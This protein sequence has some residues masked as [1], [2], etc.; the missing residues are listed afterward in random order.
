V[1]R[2]LDAKILREQRRMVPIGGTDSHSAF[3]RATTFVMSETRNENG[4]RDGLLAGR[5]CVRSPSACTFEARPTQLAPWVGVGGAMSGV[6]AVEVRAIGSSV[7][8]L[9]NG[10]VLA[11]GAKATLA[12]DPTQCSVLRAVVDGGFS[13]PIYANCAFAAEAAYQ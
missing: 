8:Y 10:E 1:S 11:R 5:V 2:T 12:V 3:L 7:Q 9:A 4:I 13:A 6:A